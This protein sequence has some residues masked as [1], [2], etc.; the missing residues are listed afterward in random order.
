MEYAPGPSGVGPDN[1]LDIAGPDSRAPIIH[2]DGREPLPAQHSSER[3]LWRLPEP[4]RCCQ[5]CDEPI[6]VTFGFSSQALPLGLRGFFAGLTLA[7]FQRLASGHCC[8]L[9]RG[10]TA[11]QFC[12]ALGSLERLKMRSSRWLRIWGFRGG[13]RICATL[14][15]GI[16]SY[17]RSA[18]PRG[19]ASA[20]PFRSC[21]REH[22]FCPAESRDGT[23]Q[24]AETDV[25]APR[26]RDERA[27]SEAVMR[28]NC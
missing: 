13:L 24:N 15:F 26:R 18:R 10:P 12:H 6:A 1:L 3:L 23:L 22:L 11:A 25:L 20:H 7:F 21:H 8:W 28:V 5:D 2:R 4:P 19:A 27:C 16:G 9:F 17:K 14:P